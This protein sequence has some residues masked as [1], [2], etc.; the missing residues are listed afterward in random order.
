MDMRLSFL[1]AMTYLIEYISAAEDRC[2]SY[3]C[4]ALTAPMCTKELVLLDGNYNYT[5]QDCADRTKQYCPW[6]SLVPGTNATVNCQDKQA[7]KQKLYP[8]YPCAAPEDCFSTVC[9][10]K[11][12]G[13]IAEGAKCTGHSECMMGLFCKQ[14]ADDKTCT[15]QVNDTKAC[16]EDEDCLNT[17]G[18]NSEKCVPYFTLKDGVTL[19]APNN[20][21]WSL[22]TSG[23]S[24]TDSKCRTRTNTVSVE[25]PCTDTC[26]YTNA[27]GSKTPVADACKCA[28]NA[29][30]KKYCELANG[31]KL[32]YSF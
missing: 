20:N 29:G 30:S 2:R 24:G 8:G 15:K 14:N 11:V 3:V 19:S 1:L 13:G 28:F 18:C 7:V 5:L 26:E 25:T 27:D 21:K 12:C 22:C 9:A 4:G 16:K 32:L 10:N 31:N 23:E 17:S 6:S